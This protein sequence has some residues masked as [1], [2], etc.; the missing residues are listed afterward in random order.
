[1]PP[2]RPPEVPRTGNR[3]AW[4]VG[5]VV[6]MG[7]A[8]LLFTTALP[9]TGAGLRGPEQGDVLPDFAA[10][11]ATSNVDDDGRRQRL[12]DGEG[13]ATTRPGNAPACQLVS[14]AHLQRLR[15]A[16]EAAD[17]DLRVRQGRRLRPAG[18]PRR[19]A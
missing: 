12:P 16:Q 19:S 13:T 17:P 9:N 15:G 3:Y 4:V 5:I 14:E 1:M 18:G 2:Q 10:P 11:L 7:I 6:F 8:V